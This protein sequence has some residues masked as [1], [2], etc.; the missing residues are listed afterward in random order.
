MD[1]ENWELLINSIDEILKVTVDKKPLVYFTG[2]TGCPDKLAIDFFKDEDIIV[3][4]RDG[5][6]WLHGEPVA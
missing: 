5:K 2:G 3:Q 4:T 1:L 6:R